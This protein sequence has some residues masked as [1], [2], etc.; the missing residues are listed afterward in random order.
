MEIEIEQPIEIFLEWDYSDEPN[1]EEG[2][3]EDEEFIIDQEDYTIQ[4]HIYIKVLEHTDNGDHWNPPVG[5]IVDEDIEVYCIQVFNEDVEKIK[6]TEKEYT[7]L[8][9]EIIDNINYE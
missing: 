2:I 9:Q 4:A 3:F 1:M 5:D 8:R 7:L 6:L